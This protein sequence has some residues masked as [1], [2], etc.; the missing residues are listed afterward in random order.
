MKS[1]FFYFLAIWA[2]SPGGCKSD[3]MPKAASGGTELMPIFLD[4]VMASKAI[5]DDEVDGFF[6]HLSAVD[7]S[8]QMKQKEGFAS[9]DIAV[10]AYKYF[11]RTQVE[12]F[13]E[14][15]KA[16]MKLVFTEVNRRLSK[17]NKNL[18][19]PD[20]KLVKLKLDHYG[21][22]VYYTRG[23]LICIPKN[24]LSRSELKGQTNVMLHEIWHIL[25]RNDKGLRD[26]IYN[27]VGFE[28]H[29]KE[30]KLSQDMSKLLLSNPDGVST[31]YAINLGDNLMALPIITSQQDH[32]DPSKP[33]IFDYFNFDLYEIDQDGTVLTNPNGSTTIPPAK[34]AVFFKKIKDNTQYIIHP[35]EITA[36]NFMLAVNA[37]DTN[38]Y[39]NYSPEGRKLIEDIIEILKN[40]Y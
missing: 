2:L 30:I 39:G 11:L 32:Y 5:V 6:D 35:D 12:D 15:D 25:S 37:Y 23:N 33:R 1:L 36:D 3:T 13:S 18:I 21:E 4:S 9:K 22:D 28:P 16:Y 10:V 19:I 14:E 29:G 20:I 40:Y 26:K 8:I 24:S 27:L 7:I 17:I 34:N 31:D 38:T